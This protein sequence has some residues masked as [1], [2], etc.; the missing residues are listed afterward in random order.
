MKTRN[1]IM[2]TSRNVAPAAMPAMVGTE[3]ESWEDFCSVPKAEASEAVGERPPVDTGVGI[4]VAVRIGPE[5]AWPSEV[6]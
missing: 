5:A 3:R 1:V 2:Q 4:P 6:G